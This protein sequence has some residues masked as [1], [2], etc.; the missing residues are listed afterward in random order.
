YLGGFG[1]AFAVGDADGDGKDEIAMALSSSIVLLDADGDVTQKWSA[2]KTVE[3]L[4]IADANGDG[5]AEVIAGDKDYSGS[6][7]AYRGSDGANLWTIVNPSDGVAGIATGDV[8]GDGAVEVVWG[9]SGSSILHVANAVTQ[10]VE[11][12]SVDVDPPFQAAV[13]DLNGD[14]K[15]ELIAGSYTTRGNSTSGRI[16]VRDY[17]SRELL[18]VLPMPY[19]FAKV[20]SIAVGQLD[21]DPQLE[22][23]ALISQFYTPA[24]Y[25]WDGS[26]FAIERT[27][28][29]TGGCCDL[30]RPLIIANLDADAVSEII[31]SLIYGTVQVLDGATLAVQ[32]QKTVSSS[33]NDFAL[34]DVNADG[35][36]DLVIAHNNGIAVYE[37][38]GWTERNSFSVSYPYPKRVA[39]AE[40]ASAFFV[41]Q[42]DSVTAYSGSTFAQLWQCVDNDIAAIGYAS[43]GGKPRLAVGLQSGILK[44]HSVA[45]GCANTAQK[46]LDDNRITDLWFKDV[47]SDGRPELLLA[48]ESSFEIDSIGW[49]SERGDVNRDTILSSADLDPLVEHFY[50]DLRGV[51]P[52][53]D[54]DGDEAVTQRDLYYLINYLRAG[55]PAPLP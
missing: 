37:T 15:L 53:A 40:D 50:G 52:A 25:I 27:R 17:A 48:R 23:A 12:S 29:N 11:W 6:V 51:S 26:T 32:V 3:A 1:S 4:A 36:R 38:Q 39:I 33:I 19:N 8:D 34:G 46:N 35:V 24:L 20:S 54:V 22:I 14:G 9:A 21:G 10:A 44:F 7:H 47:D 13:G 18:A 45:D 30:P 43:I 55:G 41:A 16:E 5:T 31:L 28:V 2:Q 42:E 49:T